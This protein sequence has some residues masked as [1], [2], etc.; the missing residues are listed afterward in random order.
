MK[1]RFLI[2]LLLSLLIGVTL[3]WWASNRSTIVIS[4]D[5]V[6]GNETMM[7]LDQLQ[8][9]V[10]KTIDS[11][12]LSSVGKFK[13][14]IKKAPATPMV[15]EL[16]Y[17]MERAPLLCRRGDN[18]KVSSMGGLALN[19][20]VDGSEESEL[21]RQFYQ[22]YVGQTNELNKI[23][24]RYAT[25]QN[26]SDEAKSVAREYN[27]LYRTIK[28]DQIAFIVTN[29]STMAAVYALFQL[30]PGDSYIASQSS[31]LIYM[32]DVLSGIRERYPASP[33]VALLEH[34]VEDGEARVEL[35]NSMTYSD[36]PELSINDMFGKKVSLSSL[37]G[38]VILVDF[39]SA[40]AG[41]SNRNNVG[42]KGI[43]NSYH[44]NSFEIYQVGIDTSK[45][46]WI[47][48]VQSQKL[49]WI[50][51]SDLNGT[52]SQSLGYYNITRVPS[53]ILISKSGDIV[54]RD[55]YGDALAKAVAAEVQK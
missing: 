3:V 30:L 47:N 33:Y 10:R 42:L 52:R 27:S 41:T 51:V 26:E 16:R 45:A 34:K 24:A 43:Y 28:Q 15:Y 32:R 11:V 37:A 12:E 2:P 18:I 5:L 17:E 25:F 39:W 40:E 36:F 19:Y 53:N 29:K 46:V 21:L 4:G 20:S 35:L 31:D 44:D 22:Q 14:V 38:K 48:A 8:S 54:G 13:F 1:S 55:L 9:G 50:S 23:A 6:R 7:Y 49:P